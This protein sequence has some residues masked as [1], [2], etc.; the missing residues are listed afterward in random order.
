[1][2]NFRLVAFSSTFCL[3]LWFSIIVVLHAF[4]PFC[5]RTV[6]SRGGEA[7]K[8][9]RWR[10]RWPIAR[11]FCPLDMVNKT[12]A[13]CRQPQQPRMK[14]KARDLRCC[15]CCCCRSAKKQYCCHY[16]GP[17]VTV[18]SDLGHIYDPFEKSH[19][20]MSQ[21][22]EELLQQPVLQYNECGQ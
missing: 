11:L 4:C 20:T 12:M 6:L 10:P 19:Q 2:D 13:A 8:R 18:S 22:I 15:C 16:A 9:D 21:Q 7:K 3:H 17:T 5:S 1:M 14:K